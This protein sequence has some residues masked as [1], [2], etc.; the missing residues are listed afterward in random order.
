M[1]GLHP[2]RS[3]SGNRGCDRVLLVVC[4]LTGPFAT[5]RALARGPEPPQLP[6][7][8][9]T[10]DHGT[11]KAGSAGVPS[12]ERRSTKTSESSMSSKGRPVSICG[13][14]SVEAPTIAADVILFPSIASWLRALHH[15]RDCAYGQPAMLSSLPNRPDPSRTE[16]TWRRNHASRPR[17]RPAGWS[18]NRNNTIARNT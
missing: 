12:R 2:S 10:H 13:S 11:R 16:A 5:P 9:Q 4:K 6:S 14:R 1:H 8:L 18:A 3:H 17:L 15:L 7:F